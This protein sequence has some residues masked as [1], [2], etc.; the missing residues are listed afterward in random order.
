M[1]RVSTTLGVAAIA[2]A[3]LALSAEDFQPLMKVT[4]TTWPAKRHIGVICHYEASRDQVEALARAAGEGSLITVVDTHRTEEASVAATLLA[5]HHADYVVLLPKDRT[6]GDGSFGA[7]VA[8]SRLALRG[9]P[10]IGTK[11]VA[12]RQGAAFS[13]GEGTQ[14]Q[15]LVNDKVLG[16]ID[17]TLPRAT[18][19]RA[20]G[21]ALASS[22]MAA[23]QVRAAR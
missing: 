21:P 16:T 22:G 18:A 15:L 12:L 13:V 14:G 6:F 3:G 11:P 8:V 9:L 1:N 4:Q 19:G 17:V 2:L 10:A 7:T 23:I 5:N 20:S